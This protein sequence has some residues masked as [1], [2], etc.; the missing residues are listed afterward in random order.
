M[1][2]AGWLAAR[3][4][5]QL[6]TCSPARH[7]IKESG[8]SSSPA[9]FNLLGRDEV[10]FSFCPSGRG[11]A[12]ATEPAEQRVQASTILVCSLWSAVQTDYMPGLSGPIS[13]LCGLRTEQ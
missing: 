4:A 12:A 10:S 13:P 5:R 9:A 8:S 1:L 2:R 11:F 3:T 6:Q 7:F